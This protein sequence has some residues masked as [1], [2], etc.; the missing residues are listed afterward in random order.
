MQEQTLQN[1]L[2]TS[3]HILWHTYPCIHTHTCTYTNAHAHTHAHTHRCRHSCSHA[4]TE[5]CTYVQTHAHTGTHTEAL[6]Y[7]HICMHTHIISHQSNSYFPMSNNNVLNYW[8]ILC[9]LKH[10]NTHKKALGLWPFSISKI[11]IKYWNIYSFFTY[12]L[13]F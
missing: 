7:A 11:H 9:S 8:N 10:V 3:T 1:H 6:T 2:L 12:K 4:C 5:A 13:V